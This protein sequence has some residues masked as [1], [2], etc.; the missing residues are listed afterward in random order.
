MKYFALIL[1]MLFTI[2]SIHGQTA[3]EI[4]PK[5]DSGDEDMMRFIKNNLDYPIVARDSCIN[6]TVVVKFVITKTGQLDSI[7]V[8]NSIHQ[9][10]DK[11]AM[12]VVKLMN[13]HWKPGARNDTVVNVS[14]R[15]PIKFVLRNAGC[16]DADFFY[17]QGVKY[18]TEN[19]YEKAIASFDSAIKLNP[20]DIDALYNSAVINIKLHDIKA[21]CI[22]LNKISNLGKPDGDEL[23]KKYCK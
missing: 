3:N 13:G 17:D 1:G 5:F 12:R 6:G 15:L 2:I 20:F 10:L 21:A 19:N 14:Y 18:S 11:E 16:Q 23:L 7:R 4:M 8:T 9:S 22:Y